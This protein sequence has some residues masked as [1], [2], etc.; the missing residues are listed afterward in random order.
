MRM[1]SRPRAARRLVPAVRAQVRAR[2][3][4]CHPRGLVCWIWM[5]IGTHLS[6]VSTI[7]TLSTGTRLFLGFI[8]SALICSLVAIASIQVPDRVRC[9]SILISSRSRP[10]NRALK[11]FSRALIKG[12]VTW[13]GLGESSALSE[14][15]VIKCTLGWQPMLPVSGFEITVIL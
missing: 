11:I 2:R 13:L 14:L 1:L 9:L 7:T 4:W 15:L 10:W 3:N 5:K 8:Q 12:S 6:S